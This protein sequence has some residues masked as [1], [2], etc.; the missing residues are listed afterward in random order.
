M[1]DGVSLDQRDKN[2]WQSF[3]PK[4]RHLLF[5]YPYY[6]MSNFSMKIA[7]TVSM[8]TL[9]ATAMSAS[10]VSAASEFLPY[11]ELLASNSVISNQT[12]EMGY[13]LNDNITRGELS[14]VVANLGG[15]D[16]TQC[17]GTVYGDVN[18]NL[19]DLCGYIEALAGAGVVSTTNA[20]FRPLAPV[21]R[22]EMTKMILGALG[23]SPSAKSAGY[24]DVTASL[25]DLA[26]YINRA[27][28]LKCAA[29]APYFRVNATSTRG[30]TFKIAACAA[31]LK[32]ETTP[33]DE[34]NN[35]T[36][37][38][39]TNTGVTTV[40]GSVAVALDGVAVAQYVPYN[41]SSVKAGSIKFTAGAA[42]TKITSIVVKRSGL[43]NV[44][45]IASL[46]LSQNGVAVS[47]TRS[48]SSSSQMATLKF[49]TPLVVK[50]GTSTSVDILVNLDGTSTNY[51]NNQHQF[52]LT[53]VNVL[54]GAAT[55]TPV[56]LGLLNTTSYKVGNI[57]VN[58]LTA[59]S[60]TS[61]KTNQTV[62]T[63]NLTAGKSTT[64]NSFTIT[65]TSGEDFNKVFANAK[66]YY[67]GKAI[68]TVTVS[69]DKIIVT[70]LNI[71][72]LNGE[73]ANIEIRAD[74]IYI[75]NSANTIMKI[76]QST[77]V[78]AVEKAT[79]YIMTVSGVPTATAT[80]TLAS[81]DLSMT[82]KSTGSTNVAPGTSAVELYN[83]E[84]T[85][86][87][88]FDV[89][90]Y[91][92]TIS[93]LDGAGVSLGNLNNFVD[94]KVT[95]YIDGNDTELTTLT[96]TFTTSADRFRVEPG[97]KVKVRIVGNVKS[98]ASIPSKYRVTLGLA[99]VRNVSNG[100]TNNFGGTPKTLQGDEVTVNNGTYTVEKPSTI[101]SNKT[102]QEGSQSDVVYFN[103][104]AS[105]EDQVLKQLTVNSVTGGNFDQYATKIALVQGTSEIQSITNS[106]DLNSNT[107]TFT[108]IN[109]LLTKDVTMPF[110]IR[111]TL[112]SGDV[113]TL[114][115]SIKL[116][117][118]GFDVRRNVN[119]TVVT[120]STST[121]PLQ[122]KP[123]QVSSNTPVVTLPAQ[124]FKNTTIQFAN[125]SAYDIEVTQVK[126][127]MTRNAVNGNYLQWGGA[128]SSVKFLDSVNGTAVGTVTAPS[129]P[130]E[131][132]VVPTGLRV[133]AGSV[134][135]IIELVD[136]A[137]TVNDADYTV[138]VKEIKFKYIDRTNSSNVS[139]II[140]ESVNVAK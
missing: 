68:G 57:S 59:G 69:P 13:R 116:N 132:T 87:A 48:M 105:A 88:T 117:V 23:E 112:K 135:R 10:L 47:S 72:R 110:M 24:Q 93:A 95:L 25:G 46:Q 26:G 33:T 6:F 128:G 109:K 94:N 83:A 84:I 52:T 41:A 21:T 89:S 37:T 104:R 73:S 115:N 114:G 50:A 111:V 134:S 56:T 2:F 53:K 43:G 14:K 35:N 30:E 130:G 121:L 123:Y 74:G 122:G 65:K 60:I 120:T 64:I 62:A 119:Q 107:Y 100:Q 75:G 99:E 140:T 124:N 103:V 81:V 67:N 49:S 32:K 58:S 90:N 102:I 61:G 92:V 101:P 106:T 76:D 113:T 85:S 42:D 4:D 36:G 20:N 91:T 136:N 17:T 82:K 27:N 55:G 80:L 45:G 97:T 129:I 28:E 12:T 138:T 16:T 34:T 66:A 98:T 70:G 96:K 139:P 40:S 18:S 125:A 63:V 39:E 15:I 71:A 79:G 54:N 44:A 118:T 29:N 126:F 31:N 137:N 3:W 1:M 108:N 5:F 133:G 78:S 51:Q 8:V 19:G 9:V 7:S 22:A 77:D 38:G 11:A 131:V 86:S 127:D